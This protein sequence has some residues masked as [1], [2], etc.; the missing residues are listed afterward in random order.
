MS[1]NPVTGIVTYTLAEWK[2]ESQLWERDGALRE[3]ERIIKLLEEQGCDCHNVYCDKLPT[4]A[5]QH[6]IALI[7]GENVQEPAVSTNDG[8]GD[9]TDK[10]RKAI[11][12]MMRI[13]QEIGEVD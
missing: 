9:F 5:A 3:R 2:E 10:Q 7:K 12:E 6:L 4:Y 13:S 1:V 11:K 8:Q